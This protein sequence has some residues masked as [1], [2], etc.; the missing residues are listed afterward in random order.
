MVVY[1]YAFSIFM[2][3]YKKNY[4]PAYPASA[5]LHIPEVSL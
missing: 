1:K 2:Y 5:K 3:L 4:N